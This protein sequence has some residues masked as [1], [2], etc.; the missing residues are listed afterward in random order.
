MDIM[1]A[2]AAGVAVGGGLVVYLLGRAIDRA[3][4]GIR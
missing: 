2:I 3:V 4:S 1:L